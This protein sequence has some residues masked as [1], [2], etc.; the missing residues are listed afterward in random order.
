MVDAAAVELLFVAHLLSLISGSVTSGCPI[1]VQVLT[2]HPLS[3][4]FTINMSNNA[5][6]IA[7]LDLLSTPPTFTLHSHLP[8][9]SITVEC[10]EGDFLLLLAGSL[11]PQ[12]AFMKKRLKIKGRLGLAMKFNSVIQATKKHLPPK[13]KL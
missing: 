4:N 6:T 13:S 10:S 12:E 7:S 9:S 2:F 5:P 8:K 1:H 11:N 3:V